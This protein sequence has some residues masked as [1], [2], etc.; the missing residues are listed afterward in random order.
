M[1][2][3][4]QLS[5]RYIKF[6]IDELARIAADACGGSQWI[7][8]GKFADGMYNKSLLFS[9]DDGAQVVGKVPN[10]NA[11]DPISQRRLRLQQWIL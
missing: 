4:R 11:E 5:E 3:A 8:V 6:N 10:P 2:E 1:D 9:M 7:K